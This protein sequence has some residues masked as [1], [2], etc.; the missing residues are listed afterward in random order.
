[1]FLF[2]KSRDAE[3][4]SSSSNE[5]SMS[6]LMFNALWATLPMIEFQPDGT[7]VRANELF[8]GAVGYRLSEIEGQHHQMF[9]DA[10]TRNSEEYRSFWRRLGSGDFEQGLVKRVNKAGDEIWLEAS[11]VPVKNEQGK[12][13]KVVKIAADVT[14][15][16]R[17]ANELESIVDAVNRSNAVIEF[18]PDGTIIRAND[19]FHAGMGYERGE[20]EGKHHRIFCEKSFVSSPEYTNLWQRLN[21]GEYYAGKI[22]RI[23]KSGEVIFL[24]ATYNP[25]FDMN[26]KLYKVMKFASDITESIETSQRTRELAMNSSQQAEDETSKGMQVVDKAINAMQSVTNGLQEA[27]ESIGSLSDQSEQIGNIVSTITAIADQ[28]NLLALN[29]AIEAAR[30]GEQGRGFAVVADEVRNLA[31]RTSDSTAEIEDVVKRNTELATKAVKAMEQIVTQSH[32]GTELIEE[33]GSAIR[34]IS[35]STREMVSVVNELG[36]DDIAG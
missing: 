16:V 13:V 28:T 4:P 6:G 7:I 35:D 25:I 33:T 27:S 24:E 9:C 10:D 18:N 12:T 20:L 17:R 36:S 30:A 26:G 21:S 34:H 8:L 5:Q 23:K 32:Q 15:R 19:N 2:S 22:K 3:K 1:M 29:A 31:A 14:D 11:Y